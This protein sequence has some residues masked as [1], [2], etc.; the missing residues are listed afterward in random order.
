VALANAGS[1]S[2]VAGSQPLLRSTRS[3]TQELVRLLSSR[4]SQSTNRE[5]ALS[6]AVLVLEAA[7]ASPAAVP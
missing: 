3:A 5:R 2:G 6:V 1:A 4:A 7:V